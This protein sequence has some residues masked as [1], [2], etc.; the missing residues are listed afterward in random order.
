MALSPYSRKVLRRGLQTLSWKADDPNQ[1]TLVYDVAYRRVGESRFRPLRQG[2][3]DPVY[4]W[5]TTALPNGRYVVKVTA[6]DTP[7]N[8]PAWRSR[9]RRRARPFEIDN[10]PPGIVAALVERSPARVRVTARDDGSLI[11]RAEYAVDGQRWTEV[12][13][14][15]G[16]NDS[17]RRPTRSRRPCGD[18]GTAHRRGAGDRPAGQRVERAGEVLERRASERAPGQREAPD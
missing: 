4:A 12:Y 11:R 2:L 16:I 14:K 6:R 3:T 10:S 7:T 9:A 1:D 17:P 5:D 15:D 8:P 13:P 18:A